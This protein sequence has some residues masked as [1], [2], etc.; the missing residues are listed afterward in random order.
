MIW[1][2]TTIPSFSFRVRKQLWN[3]RPQSS[4]GRAD[5]P[6]RVLS[7]FSSQDRHDRQTP[8]GAR[9][10]FPALPISSRAQAVDP[11]KTSSPSALPPSSCTSCAV[12]TPLAALAKLAMAVADKGAMFSRPGG[13]ARSTAIG[14]VPFGVGSAPF[15]TGPECEV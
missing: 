2:N 1:L 7:S 15:G 13:G 6:H 14:I 11:F 3:V 8:V 5:Y 12:V 9:Q 4:S 10:R